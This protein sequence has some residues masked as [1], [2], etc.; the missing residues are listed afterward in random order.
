MGSDFNVD[1][2]VGM[3]RLEAR[4]AE[5]RGVG[6]CALRKH[7]DVSHHIRALSH[8]TQETAIREFFCDAHRLKEEQQRLSC[9]KHHLCL[10]T[11]VIAEIKGSFAVGVFGVNIAAAA[12]EQSNEIDP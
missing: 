2:C 11:R 6:P 5:K 12:D 9:L 8:S 10:D 1:V 3:S 7:N 4:N